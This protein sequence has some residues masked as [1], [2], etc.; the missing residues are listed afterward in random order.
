[1]R[2]IYLDNAA[3][4]RVDR[5]VLE[6]ML[7]YF[8]DIYG[9]PSSLHSFGHEAKKAL[10]N[11]RDIAAQFINSDPQEIIFTGSG[12]ESDN[13]AIKGVAYANFKKGNHIITTAIEH[14][15]VLESCHWLQ[16]SG[17]DVSYIPVHPNGILNLKELK[18][19]IKKSTVLISVMHA[20][21]EICTIQPVM[22]VGKIAR[23]NNTYFHMDAVQTLGHIKIDV[24]DIGVDLLSASAHKLYGPKGVGL[25]YIRKGTRINPLLNGGSQENNLRASTQNVS[26]IVGFGKAIELASLLMEK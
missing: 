23:E 7:P 8:S 16:K 3:T 6:E 10:E 18:K 20:N 12:T 9:N 15:A 13:M 2:K 22:E 4:T 26:G 5:Q 19:A 21:N 17:F 11:A 25:L 14:H 1:M 24:E